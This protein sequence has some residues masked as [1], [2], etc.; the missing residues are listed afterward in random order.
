MDEKYKE[1]HRSQGRAEEVSAGHF[2][3]CKSP[4][5]VSVTECNV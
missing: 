5:S 4:C 2:G 3:V 1:H